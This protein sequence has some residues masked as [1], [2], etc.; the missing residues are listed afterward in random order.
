VTLVAGT[1]LGPYE[2]LA[3]IGAGG[4]GEVYRARDPRLGREVAVKVLPAAVSSNPERMRRFEKEARAASAL[5]H[6][7]IVT[8]HDVGESGGVVFLAMELVEGRTLREVLA[9]GAVA[10]R[11]LLTI[12]AQVAEGLAK[13]HGA[14]IVHRDLK[15]ENVMV[16]PD[17]FAKIL[18]FG[19]AK[20][21]EAG[22]SGGETA[23]PTV[24]GATAP[25]VVM[26][27]AG[28]MSPEQALGKPVDFRSDQFSLGAIL[29]EMATGKRA[30]S[31][32]SAPATLA[33][34]IHEEPES[35]AGP[36]PR[37]PAPLR[38]LVERC[39]A[40]KP[41]DRYAS[42]RDL[43][44]DLA[45][46]RDRL[47]ESGSAALSPA[48][49][50]AR[51]S[52]SWGALAVVATVL[53]LGVAV[54]ATRRPASP[55]APPVRFSVV[56]PPGVL[57]SSGEIEGHSSLSPDGRQLV[58]AGETT[59]GR[60]LYLRS[61]DSLETHPLAGT[62]GGI[63]PF[64]SPDSRSI[65]F[66]A[67]GKLLRL[68]LAGGPPRLVCEASNLE[69]LPSWGSS[70]QILFA[71]IGPKDPGIYVVGAS[72]GE[73]HRLLD[74][75]GKKNFG[76]WPHFLPDG[77]RFLYLYLD[78]EKREAPR[79]Y[80]RAGSLDSDRTS[81]I[82]DRIWSRV[83]Y[84]RGALI[85]ASQGV[86]LAQPFDAENLRFSGAAVTL[87][88][89]VYY[90]NG[91][92]MAGFSASPAGVIAYEKPEPA[93]R[94]YWVDRSGREAETVPLSG[95]L[96]AVRVSPDGRSLASQIRNE[97]T[98]TSDIWLY[99]LSR[100]LPL[101]LTLDEG[102]DQAPIW[103]ADGTKLFFRSDRRG[104]PDLYEVPAN[105]PG[106]DALLLER[107]GVQHPD[108]VSPDGRFLIFTEWSR[109]TN[110]DLWLLPLAGDGKPRPL[111]QSV[112]NERNA[113][114]APDGRWIAFV[115]NESGTDE[116]YLRPLEGAGERIRVSSQGGARPR[117]RRDG[118]ELFYLS[119]DS[120][121]V[122]VPVTWAPGP[123]PGVAT[124]LF[125]LDGEV[126]DFDVD[127]SGKRFLVDVAP[128]D[129]APIG[130]LLNWPSLLGKPGL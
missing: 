127:A 62:E 65:G 72:G 79:W 63:S 108:D 120:D 47:S 128:R 35:I 70:G 15:P 123:R 81:V 30:F 50:A 109:R 6:P 13:A 105:S 130:V 46:L 83:E 86:L 8:I 71:Q 89:R 99:D 9:E 4:M 87:A 116:I 16:T 67:N 14:G 115:S 64:W 11:S 54:Y 2:I 40:K 88:D 43:A 77:K 119:A 32:A 58:F 19:L 74:S 39:L 34:I 5:N 100:R 76:L 37:T 98:G 33:A 66:F 122:S 114:F 60:R 126:H 82:S 91:P 44:R 28:Y 85:F 103:S 80:L 48:A 31:R 57:F 23:A 111:E 69:T 12:A 25:G 129:P 124:T 75:G 1:R 51:T 59:E 21:T 84:A 107:P 61:L 106:R 10:T 18:D 112:Y 95:V 113:R 26:G 55:P 52:R 22:D 45:T 94:A 7:N 3:P 96:G 110:G 101:R 125:R 97:K 92:A 29:Y 118:R 36:S 27:T 42:T 121:I 41:D 78:F 104:P 56:P 24:T 73:P 20:L 49:P 68:D 102:D 17:G 38:W 93:H 90:F 117:W 53:A